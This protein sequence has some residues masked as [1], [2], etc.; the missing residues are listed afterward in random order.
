VAEIVWTEDPNYPVALR[1]TV[2]GAS[3]YYIS[4]QYGLPGYSVISA[5]PWEISRV[6][7]GEDVEA[8]KTLCQS[9]LDLFLS[10]V[11]A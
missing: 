3:Y 9:Q 5:L 11:N 8:L 10:V 6:N 4:P 2:E 1:G 7:T